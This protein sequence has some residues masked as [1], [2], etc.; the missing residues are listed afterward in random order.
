MQRLQ[1]LFDE[2]PRVVCGLMS[3]TSLDGVDAAVARLS[4]SGRGLR[5]ETLSYAE[6]PYGAVLRKYLLKNST[7]ETSSVRALSQLDVRVAHSYNDAV[8]EAVDEAGLDM[9][10]LDLVGSHGQTVHHVP[11]PETFADEEIHSTLQIGDPS[12]LANLLRTP[13]VG[14][15]RP[16]DMAC[17]GQGAPLVPYFDYTLFS[18]PDETRGM[19]NLGGIANLTVLPAGAS[20]GEVYAFD[21][22]PADMVIDA[23]ME[24]LFDAPYDED[25]ALAS[26][27]RVQTDLLDTLIAED[28]YFDRPPPKST[29][30]ERYGTDYAENLLARA[31]DLSARDLVATATALTAR[32]VHLAYEQFI[33]EHD[34]LDALI[35]SGGGVW[36]RALMHM[37]QDLFAGVEVRTSS[38]YG[39]DSDAKEALCSAVFAHET[40]N[41]RPVNLPAVT[42]ADRE[43]L[44][45]KVCVPR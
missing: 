25:G 36:N 35:I 11:D 5:C 24:R 2:N 8:R 12:V 14:D 44:L 34:P 42:G 20:S 6:A 38:H 37:L 9:D 7:D 19:L 23:L 28:D 43:T 15:F 3:G 32:S 33:E 16:A 39:I 30:R 13:V 21:T 45:G 31:D 4:G 18:D 10:D 41:D 26:E 27:G 40:I 22:G 17:G 1:Q 29:G